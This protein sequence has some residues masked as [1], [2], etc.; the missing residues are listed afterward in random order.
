MN[1]HL[2]VFAENPA[3]EKTWM[4]M[5]RQA[6]AGLPTARV[7]SAVEERKLRKN[8]GQ[9]LLIENKPGLVQSILS[10]VD[11]RGRAVFLIVGEHEKISE[12]ALVGL[13]DSAFD[14]ILVFPFRAL[15]VM[16][17]LRHCQQ[18]L[19]W[20]EVSK[21]NASF[22]ELIDGF[23][24]DLK[25]A[26]R[27]QKERLPIKFSDVKGFHIHH[28]YLAGLKSGGDYFDLAESPMGNALSM[29][30][31]KSSS[32]GLSSSVLTV[33][34]RVALRLTTEEVFSSADTVKR[35][36]NEIRAV[37]A[38]KDHLNLFY[39]VLSRKD[40]HLRYINLGSSRAFYANTN[41]SF[42]E[43][44][45]HQGPISRTRVEIGQD[46]E[47]SLEPKGRLIVVSD[48]YIQALGGAD[49]TRR[50]LDE[51]HNQDG[52]DVLNELAFRVKAKLKEPPEDVPAQDCTAV[53]FDVDS[54]LMRL[55]R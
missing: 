15:E 47:I 12:S 48:G 30:M 35:I 33:L 53:V 36:Q 41:E 31:T 43:L 28:R 32:Y 17:K 22:S 5:L 52:K 16:S 7:E 14:D 27:L 42:R 19:M 3:Q 10:S 38:E 45:T 54:R 55:A 25:L 1:F 49:S 29:V 2:S 37:L 46:G 23:Q 13:T 20:D 18:I 26:E 8:N 39:A 44:D 21:L 50:C 51:L 24:D 6:L 9:V 34:M 40:Y 11:R 4:E